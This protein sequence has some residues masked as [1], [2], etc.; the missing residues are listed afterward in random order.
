MSTQTK[1]KQAL[2]ELGGRA[3]LFEICA[4]LIGRGDFKD[5]P[6]NGVA[7][8]VAFCLKQLIKW[9]EVSKISYGEYKIESSRIE[10]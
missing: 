1:V 9:K 2:S 4:L 6:Y 5:Y 3:K 7:S 8:R 10:E